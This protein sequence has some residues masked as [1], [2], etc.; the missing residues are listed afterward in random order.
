[1]HLF[2]VIFAVFFIASVR[3]DEYLIEYVVFKNLQFT[4]DEVFI[5]KELS[6]SPSL[7]ISLKKDNN[8]IVIRN[9]DESFNSKSESLDSMGEIIYEEQEEQ[10]L[11]QEPLTNPNPQ[12]WFNE[13]KSLTKL[14]TLKRRIE[15]RSDYELIDSGSWVQGVF[16]SNSSK[17]VNVIANELNLYIKAYKERYLHLDVLGML[18]S[19]TIELSENANGIK[20]I[21]R[22]AYTALLN[23]TD[24][25]DVN[26]SIDIDTLF[27][28]DIETIE[29]YPLDEIIS[30]SSATLIIDEDRRVFNEQVHYFDHPQFGI[31]IYLK[32][33][34]GF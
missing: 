16:D 1:M 7:V 33:L 20:E 4:T 32:K 9:L 31:M 29:Q 15:R 6:I 28:G 30:K 24:V 23:E 2:K 25:K 34:S 26:I 10:T 3:S 18:D 22:K 13:N 5:L 12:L 19:Q 21:K 27:E 14:E 8:E 17:F 11:T